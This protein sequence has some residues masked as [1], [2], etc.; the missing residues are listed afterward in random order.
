MLYWI[1]PAILWLSSQATSSTSWW[2]GVG[3]AIGVLAICE[4][5]MYGH[6]IELFP[7]HLV[8]RDRGHPWPRE[9][10]VERRQIVEAY[11]EVAVRGDG[12]PW[13]SISLV[14]SDGTSREMIVLCVV[15]FKRSDV[16]LL[17][18]WLPVS[19]AS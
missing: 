16:A 4:R 13:D 14:T 1:I 19:V 2:A 11:R 8:Y 5:Q 7:D 17:L 6:A 12:K 15:T 9:R 10:R 3:L 18:R